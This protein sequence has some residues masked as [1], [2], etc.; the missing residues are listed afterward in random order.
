MNH[1]NSNKSPKEEEEEED[2]STMISQ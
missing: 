2:L 1:P